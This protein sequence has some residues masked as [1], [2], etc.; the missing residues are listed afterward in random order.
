MDMYNQENHNSFVFQNI[1]WW[2]R[3]LRLLLK[4][5]CEINKFYKESS[6][7]SHVTKSCQD[8]ERNVL[9]KLELAHEYFQVLKLL[10]SNPEEAR[11]CARMAIVSSYYCIY[12][13]SQAMICAVDR[14]EQYSHMGVAKSF[15]NHIAKKKGHIVEP[16]SFT[17]S[18][19]IESIYQ[20]D[21]KQLNVNAF[22]NCKPNTVEEAYS[23]CIA[24]LRTT[25]DF[26]RKEKE[27]KIKKDK[28][29]LS[30]RPKEKQLVRNIELQKLGGCCFLH[31]AYRFR[32]K[33]NYKDIHV[34]YYEHNCV[35]NEMLNDLVAISN[36]YFH[37]TLCFCIKKFDSN[38]FQ[39]SIDQFINIDY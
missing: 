8:R 2:Y 22:N 5:P 38:R 34:K 30:F 25:A 10:S 21:I 13:L 32:C 18:S 29:I 17:T 14:S 36:N 16:F 33:A 19:F 24:F 26:Y 11:K 28:G 3:S 7:I 9:H 12:F 4:D 31:Q 6:N 27:K 39:E 15:Y 1:A 35:I 23:C 37:A 20:Q